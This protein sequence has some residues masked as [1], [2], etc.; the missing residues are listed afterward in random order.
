ML[1]HLLL[2]PLVTSV[3][4]PVAAAPSSAAQP[5]FSINDVAVTEPV[6]TGDFVTATFTVTLDRSSDETVSVDYL[7]DPGA[8]G[9]S[10]L[11]T[12]TLSYAPGET[13]K[14]F[15][16]TVVRDGV[17][18]PTET[19]PVTLSNPVSAAV[20]DGQG[21]LTIHNIDPDGHWGCQAGI[22]YTDT[23]AGDR[24]GQLVANPGPTGAA[25]APDREAGVGTFEFALPLEEL[26]L[27]YPMFSVTDFVAQTTFSLGPVADPVHASGR[28]EVKTGEL[29]YYQPYS[30]DFAFI[31]GLHSY[32]HFQCERLTPS[33]S[34]GT[35]VVYG[36]A[37]NEMD[38]S[39]GASVGQQV[40]VLPSGA[41][42]WLNR[43][44]T[45]TF[46]AP[47]GRTG[48]VFRVQPVVI[49]RP[50]GSEVVFGESSVAY[51][52]NPCVR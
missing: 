38:G 27:G 48:V 16:V 44:L 25:C 21:T 40:E 6:K 47:D 46:T 35:S 36:R 45:E 37:G 34:S 9:D 14:S 28:A 31:Q 20:T 52:G 17:Y 33:I 32:I 13:A 8:G 1:R 2:A 26:G 49:V 43:R 39:V 50:D 3:L 23:A 19:F 11:A 30:R 12:G 29:T 42:V 7:A 22:A 4:I 41:V 15:G 51:V 18:E 10:Q 5:G 24:G